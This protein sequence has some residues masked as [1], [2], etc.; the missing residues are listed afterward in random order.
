MAH[1]PPASYASAG[2]L[3][4]PSIQDGD[5]QSSSY[6]HAYRSP[7]E[8]GYRRAVSSASV[9]T[10]SQPSVCYTPT[11]SSHSGESYGIQCEIDISP[12]TATSHRPP[13]AAAWRKQPHTYQPHGL[14]THSASSSSSIE[15]DHLSYADSTITLASTC[16]SLQN[17]QNSPY[18]PFP[19]CGPGY[20]SGV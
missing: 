8:S 4:F 17:S 7:I 14:P 18:A 2:A 16:D 6:Y 13:D 15:N 12:S 11:P 5:E 3:A 20:R 1:Y 10:H 19:Q 9:V